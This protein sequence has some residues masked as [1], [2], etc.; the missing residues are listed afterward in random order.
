[1]QCS[2]SRQHLGLLPRQAHRKHRALARLARHG[3]VAAH[4]ACEPA[5]DGEAQ[6]SA[7]KFPSGQRVGLSEFAEQLRLLFRRHADT[8]VADGQLNPSAVVAVIA[9]RSIDLQSKRFDDRRP[10]RD[11]S[12]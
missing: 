2:K 10:E 4:H 12:F 3:H 7:A 8:G 5:A 1:M 11:I 9:R 6:A